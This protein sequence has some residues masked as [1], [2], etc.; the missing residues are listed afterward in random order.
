[1]GFAS[2]DVVS[3]ARV[4]GISAQECGAIVT[5]DENIKRFRFEVPLGQC[6]MT[7]TSRLEFR[8]RY[9]LSRNFLFL[10]AIE[11]YHMLSSIS[12]RCR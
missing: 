2:P 6:N 9:I 7:V 10:A 8:Q 1:M 5:F 11:L 12:E 4:N 3:M